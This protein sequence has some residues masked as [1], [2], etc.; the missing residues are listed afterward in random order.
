PIAGEAAAAP[1]VAVHL[2]SM[3]PQWITAADGADTLVVVRTARVEN[4]KTVYQG[5]VLDWNQLQAALK[6]EVKDLF[7]EAKLMP[8]KDLSGSSRE[9]AM[10]AL[11]VRLDPGP[12]PEPAPAGW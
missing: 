8:L 2:G 3:H 5:V 10:T 6:E 11:P 1:P 9:Q 7:P 4:K 12:L